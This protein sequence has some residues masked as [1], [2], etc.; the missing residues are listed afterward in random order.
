MSRSV[1]RVLRLPLRVVDVQDGLAR[2]VARLLH[3]HPAD[4]ARVIHA[5]AFKSDERTF[6][7][8]LLA[9]RTQLW[10]Y[11]T[12]Q[13]VACGDFVVV[14]RSSPTRHRAWV[15]ELK[16][17]RPVRLGGAW[18]LRHADVVIDDLVATGA[19][20][21]HTAYAR[22]TGGCHAVLAWFGCG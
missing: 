7:R 2:H 20:V 10:V 15:I 11:R 1:P 14:D 19:L 4:L 17:G 12:H 9:R 8:S 18:Q 3:P 5:F 21:P 16:H 22:L 6:A 13:A